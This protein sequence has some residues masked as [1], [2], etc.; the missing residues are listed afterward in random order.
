MNINKVLE[1]KVGIKREWNN[2][3]DLLLRDVLERENEGKGVD[4]F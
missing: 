1:Y 4:D 3:S 2:L